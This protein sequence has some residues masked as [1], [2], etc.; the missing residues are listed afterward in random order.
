MMKA[1]PYSAA[2]Q[3]KSLPN[4]RSYQKR[5]N[6]GQRRK[7]LKRRLLQVL[8]TA[9]PVCLAS[10]G[11]LYAVGNL[12]S[13]PPGTTGTAVETAATASPAPQPPASSTVTPGD[14]VSAGQLINLRNPSFTIASDRGPLT[15]V[16]SIDPGLQGYLLE[17]LDTTNATYIGIV[18]M[19]VVSRRILAMVGHDRTGG[20]PNPCTDH[21]YP[22]ASIFKIVT[23]T[24]AIEA[25][26]ISPA[27]ELRY[28]GSK[29]TLYK[30]QLKNTR[31]RYTHRISLEDSFAQSVNPVFGKLGAR[32]LKK[33]LLSEYGTAFGFNSG[34]W[35]DVKSD[36][37]VL[38]ITDRPYRWAEIASGFN[39]ETVI[40]PLHGA[41]IAAAAAGDG[42][43]GG[44][45]VIDRIETSGGKVLYARKPPE[46]RRVMTVE[47]AHQVSELMQATIRTGT[48]RRAFKGRQRDAVLSR[49]DI[50]AKSG[51]IGSNPRHDWFVGFARQRSG[52]KH[53]I[54]VAVVVVHKD[55]IGKRA[56]T[57]ARQAIH[58]WFATLF[59]KAAKADK[60]PAPS[61]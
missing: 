31:N 32:Y 27:S 58:Q 43:F 29:H 45:S 13:N 7:N 6:R 30:S 4:W 15:V 19:D 38:K 61:T 9:I 24:A 48:C 28:N 18:V 1:K 41:L 53:P 37:S 5:L 36:G 35:L 55:F 49:L 22:A 57:Y 23:A 56:A 8:M 40:T 10:F 46:T 16:T 3:Q 20:S 51:S 17:R 14:L 52:G 21:L 39:R 25:L 2:R 50:G 34:G 42:T 47:T 33:E 11:I 12:D 54:A 60:S 44:S 26:G 59:A